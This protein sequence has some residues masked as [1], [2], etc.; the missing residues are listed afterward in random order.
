MLVEWASPRYEVTPTA[1]IF[2]CP[3]TSAAAAVLIGAAAV[4]ASEEQNLRE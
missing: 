2:G 1:E 3:A 4:G